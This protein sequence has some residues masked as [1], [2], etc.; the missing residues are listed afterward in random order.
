MTQLFV[1]SK[2]SSI[3]RLLTPHLKVHIFHGNKIWG[4]R[5][6]VDHKYNSIKDIS[7]KLHQTFQHTTITNRTSP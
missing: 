5:T 6:R 4:H 1:T 2:L 3:N 7:N